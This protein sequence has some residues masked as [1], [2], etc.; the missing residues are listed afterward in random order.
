MSLPVAAC[1]GTCWPY[2]S[3]LAVLLFHRSSIFWTLTTVGGCLDC[4]VRGEGR[5]SVRHRQINAAVLRFLCKFDQVSEYYKELLSREMSYSLGRSSIPMKRR[6][7]I[8]LAGKETLADEDAEFCQFMS[9][10]QISANQ[11][12][13]EHKGFYLHVTLC[14]Q[15]FLIRVLKL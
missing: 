8:R 9:P 15:N 12:L 6:F 13:E 11:S 7:M 14:K 10:Y 3:W 1:V 5:I 4:S 2:F